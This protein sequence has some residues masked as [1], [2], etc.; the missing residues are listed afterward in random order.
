MTLWYFE[1]KKNE[2]SKWGWG[3][4]FLDAFQEIR[5]RMLNL[6]KFNKIIHVKLKIFCTFQYTF[7]KKYT[8]FLSIG[9][10]GGGGVRLVS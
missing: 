7:D 3:A 9:R 4:I 5:I 10:G 1:E 6:S 2:I 8:W